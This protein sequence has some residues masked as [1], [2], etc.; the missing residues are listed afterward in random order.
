MVVVLCFRGGCVVVRWHGSGV[1]LAW[2]WHGD[3]GGVVVVGYLKGER[4][5]ER[6]REK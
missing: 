6:K 2:W 4:E 5:R 3:G 1:V